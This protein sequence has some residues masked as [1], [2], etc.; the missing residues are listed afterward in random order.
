MPKAGGDDRQSYQAG[1]QRDSAAAVV[2][3]ATTSFEAKLSVDPEA[4]ARAWVS[5]AA[6]LAVVVSLRSL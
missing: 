2:G 6:T 3:Q 4:F 5:L 1:G